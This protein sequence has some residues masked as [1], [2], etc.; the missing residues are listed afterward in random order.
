MFDVADTLIGSQDKSVGHGRYIRLREDHPSHHRAAR[1][2]ASLGGSQCRTE[3]EL[4]YEFATTLARN[5]AL[6]LVRCEMGWSV[7][8]CSQ[9]RL[10]LPPTR[11]RCV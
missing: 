9:V 10:K 6:L 4:V 1:F 8:G 11:R 3:E 7:A 2:L 5:E